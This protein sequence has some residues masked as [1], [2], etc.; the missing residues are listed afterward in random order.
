MQN[1]FE[2]VRN[3]SLRKSI[4]RIILQKVLAKIC[5][6]VVL[7]NREYIQQQ[8]IHK[9][10]YLFMEQSGLVLFYFL[11]FLGNSGCSFPLLIQKICQIP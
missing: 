5:L 4:F 2:N 11:C 3:V 8:L 10:V 1:K 6:Y 7:R 9:K